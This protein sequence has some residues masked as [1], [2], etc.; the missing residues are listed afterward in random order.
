MLEDVS[1]GRTCH[2]VRGGQCHAAIMVKVTA[3]SNLVGL[4][5]FGE[6]IVAQDDYVPTVDYDW[7]TP[8]V[9]SRWHWWM[10]HNGA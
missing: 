4:R 2:Y 7:S 8:L 3:G 9:N 10:D 6:G 5:V 1:V